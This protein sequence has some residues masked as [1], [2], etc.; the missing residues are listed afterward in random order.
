MNKKVIAEAI[1]LTQDDVD[2]LRDR[3]AKCLRD[4]G[5]TKIKAEKVRLWVLF[6]AYNDLWEANRYAVTPKGE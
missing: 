5:R 4:M 1:K 2:Y 3:A 6:N